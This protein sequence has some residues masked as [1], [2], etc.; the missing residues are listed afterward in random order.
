MV[1]QGSNMLTTSPITRPTIKG[2]TLEDMIEEDGLMVEMEMEIEEVQE[3]ED[4][5]GLIIYSRKRRLK[6]GVAEMQPIEHAQG[7]EK[8]I[9]HV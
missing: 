5:R 9:Y 3:E 7:N 8:A 6:D 4:E 1:T 2:S